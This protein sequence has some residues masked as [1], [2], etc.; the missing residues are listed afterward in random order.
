MTG[1]VQTYTHFLRRDAL[2]ATEK[3]YSLRFTPPTGF[4][5][6]NIKLEK[7]DIKIRN[8]RGSGLKPSFTEDGCS[9]LDLRT[10]MQH[11][12]F[13]DEEKIKEI[14][15]KEVSNCLKTFLSAQHVQIF[16]HTVRVSILNCS[17]VGVSCSRIASREGEEA[18]RYFPHIYRT[19]LQV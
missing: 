6:T 1:I 4:P 8:I 3:P 5:R 14:Y 16:E 10:E 12:D 11:A 9:L 2:Y 19:A 7:H 17:G 15:L 13:D 18:S